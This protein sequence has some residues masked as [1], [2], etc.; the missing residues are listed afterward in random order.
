MVRMTV[1]ML[2]RLLRETTVPVK[3]PQTPEQKKAM[4]DLLKWASTMMPGSHDEL[5]KAIEQARQDDWAM[6]LDLLSTYYMMKGIRT[7]EP[8]AKRRMN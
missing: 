7:K 2:R 6:A 3:E 8:G 1:G 5:V 4:I